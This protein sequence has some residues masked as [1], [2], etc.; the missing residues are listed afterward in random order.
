MGAD[1]GG[2]AAAAVSVKIEDRDVHLVGDE[3]GCGNS[4]PIDGAEPVAPVG[5]GVVQP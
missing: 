5:L 2:G 4:Q 3:P 1:H